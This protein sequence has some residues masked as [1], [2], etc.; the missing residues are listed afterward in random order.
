MQ[1]NSS[2]YAL[3]FSSVRQHPARRRRRAQPPAVGAA[4]QPAAAWGVGW[5]C[6]C[7][8]GCVR[9]LGEGLGVDAGNAADADDDDLVAAAGRRGLHRQRH[10][11]AR[12]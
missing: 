5:G 10:G 8:E 11:I 4:G 9:D 12:L 2:A 7:D 1:P 6:T 3:P